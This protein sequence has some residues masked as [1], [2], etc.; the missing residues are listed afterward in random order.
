[1]VILLLC[2]GIGMGIDVR[3]DGHTYGQSRDNQNF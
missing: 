3:T 2:Q 1:M